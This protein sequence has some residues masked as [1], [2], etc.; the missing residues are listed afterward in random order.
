MGRGGKSPPHQ[1][2]GLGALSGYKYRKKIKGLI[3]AWRFETINY[4]AIDLTS[5]ENRVFLPTFIK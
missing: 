1:L 3:L 4:V 2:E 5:R